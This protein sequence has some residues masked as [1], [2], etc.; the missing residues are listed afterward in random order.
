MS[1]ISP[2]RQASN[3]KRSLAAMKSKLQA[4]AADWDEVDQFFLW[5]F[6]GLV[7]AVED[8]EK[9]LEEYVKERGNG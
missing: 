2:V 8:V 6:E 5:E 3:N 9:R 1:T 7:K 4:M